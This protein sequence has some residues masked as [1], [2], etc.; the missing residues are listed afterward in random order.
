MAKLT[1]D[2]ATINY[3][4]FNQAGEEVSYVR[5]KSEVFAVEVNNQVMF[6]AVQTYLSN[7][8]QATAKT[9]SRH[10]VSGGGKK[11]WRQKGTGREIGRASCRERV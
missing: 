8:R 10:E 11:P 7:R 6:D 3:P 5:L 2:T 4:L 9:K 1:V